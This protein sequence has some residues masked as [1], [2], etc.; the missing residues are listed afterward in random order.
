MTT[1]ATN[2]PYAIVR[3]A[4]RE[5]KLIAATQEP[6]SAQY[7]NWLR[8]LQDLIAVWQTQ[9]LKLFLWQDQSITLVSGQQAYTLAP[10][11]DVDISRPTQ[12]TQGYYLDSNGVRR[13]LYPLGWSDWMTLSTVT[14]TGQ[15][16]QYFI[17]KQ[18]TTMTVRF[19]LI[20]DATAATG[21]AHLLLRTRA[22]APLTL[23]ATT[24]FPDE[25]RLALV[26]GMADEL[27]TGQP[28]AV[29][30]RCQMKA[31]EYK[32]LLEGQDVEN[33]NTRF[34]LELQ[35]TMGSFT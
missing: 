35:P 33:A 13:P 12:A 14:Q 25:W 4:A 2:S 6:S 18:A 32:S 30:Q 7:A 26:W 17:D 28:I 21:T 24:C 11:G 9:G 1:P 20:P 3:D 8:R 5:A 31:M 27:A 16:T 10:G 29:I 22:T 34:A 19:W 15:I 23:T